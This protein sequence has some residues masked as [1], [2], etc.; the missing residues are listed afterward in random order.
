[1][2]DQRVEGRPALGGEDRR[3]RAVVAGVGAEAVDGL[4]REGDERARAQQPGRGGDAARAVGKPD[5]VLGA[6]G[7]RARLVAPGTPA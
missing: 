7:V 6:I 3:D 4:G 1:M 5:G 2:D